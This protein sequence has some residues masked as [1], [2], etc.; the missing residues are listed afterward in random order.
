MIFAPGTRLGPYEIVAPLGSDGMGEVYRAVDTR[1]DRAV[2][3]KVLPEALAADP[4]FRQRFEREA[5][6]ISQLTRP[7]IC[8]LYDVGEERGTTFLVMEPLEGE[9][10]ADRLTTGALPVCQAIDIGLQIAAA[11]DHAHRAGRDER[12][13]ATTCGESDPGTAQPRLPHRTSYSVR[14]PSMNGSDFRP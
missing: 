7:H 1:F 3:I 4:Q 13:G 5:R 11:L 10:L 14:K 12:A 6:A 9:T 2:A 8:G